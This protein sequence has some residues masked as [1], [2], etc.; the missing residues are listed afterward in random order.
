MVEFEPR[1]DGLPSGSAI[2]DAIDVV[3]GLTEQAEQMA[4]D[5]D[6]ERAMSQALGATFGYMV[7]YLHH[8]TI[9]RREPRDALAKAAAGLPELG[10][11]ELDFLRAAFRMLAP[12]AM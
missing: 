4:G 6:N 12:R 3:A 7:A 10:T 2:S 9:D 5:G 8:L 1:M 11:A